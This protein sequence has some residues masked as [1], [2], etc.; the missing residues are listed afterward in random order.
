VFCVD[1]DAG[2]AGGGGVRLVP[3]TLA[4]IAPHV[5]RAAASRELRRT[6]CGEAGIALMTAALLPSTT[7]YW[8][9]QEAFDALSAGGGIVRDAT[10]TGV[11]VAEATLPTDPGKQEA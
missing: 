7:T 4:D 11:P 1:G 5:R 2:V 9:S 3:V 6:G 8:V 10:R